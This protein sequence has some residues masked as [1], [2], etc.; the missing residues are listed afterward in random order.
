MGLLRLLVRQADALGRHGRYGRAVLPFNWAF[1]LVGPWLV[2]A[3]LLSLVVGSLLSFGVA[4][5]AV[6]LALAGFVAGGS[7]DALG[8]FQP[9]YALFDTQ[10]SLLHAALALQFTAADGLWEPDEALRETFNTDND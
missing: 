5:V 8:P 10:V 3:G 9:F 6:P 2:A 1:M 4:G 7:R